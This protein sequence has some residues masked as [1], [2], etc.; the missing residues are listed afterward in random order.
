MIDSRRLRRAIG[1]DSFLLVDA[2][3]GLPEWRGTRPQ[4]HVVSLMSLQFK[5]KY[6]NEIGGVWSS[7]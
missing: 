6:I 2:K 3:L 7:D 5:C 4:L 1:E